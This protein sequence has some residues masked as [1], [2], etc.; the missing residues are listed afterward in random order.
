[1]CHAISGSYLFFSRVNL[2]QYFKPFLHPFVF[3]NIHQYGNATTSLSQY[4]GAAGFM[5]LLD[6]FRNPCTECR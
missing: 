4:H 1:M 3:V 6:K 2:F 5:E